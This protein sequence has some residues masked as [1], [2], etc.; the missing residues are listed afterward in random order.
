MRLLLPT[1]KCRLSSLAI[2]KL[3]QLGLGG[4][5]FFWQE[6]KYLMTK[7]FHH[8]KKNVKCELNHSGVSFFEQTLLLFFHLML[9]DDFKIGTLE[10]HGLKRRANRCNLFLKYNDNT[11]R[12]SSSVRKLGLWSFR[13]QEDIKLF[14]KYFLK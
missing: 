11:G 6:K 5:H 7:F 1:E 3:Q 4:P 8:D 13:G 2:I 14:T 12:L 10:C 9:I